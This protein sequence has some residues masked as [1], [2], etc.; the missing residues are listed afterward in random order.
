MT[1]LF[2]QG[3]LPNTAEL[4]S[5]F[6]EYLT[7]ERS[8]SHH[9]V[10]NYEIDLRHFIKFL[11]ERCGPRIDFETQ[12]TLKILRDFL[13][14]QIKK[15]ERSTV[16]RRLSL[17]KGFLKFLHQEGYVRKNIA[18]LIRLPRAHTRLPATLKP[19]EIVQ[20]IEQL[21]L[22]CLRHKRLKAVLELLYSAGLRVSELVGLNYADLDLPK[23]QVRVLGKGNK[24]RLV[25]IG[26][27]CR[28][29]LGEYVKAVPALQKRGDATPTFLN[30]SGGRISVR[31]IQRELQAYAIQVL[32]P[33]GALVTPHTFR[34]SCATHLLAN[35]AGLREIQELLG[36]RTLVTTQKYTH[37][38]IERLKVSY[39]SAHPKERKRRER[40]VSS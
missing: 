16:A 6:L 11:S 9:T 35:G 21:P 2:D 31:S 7:S 37:L 5:F 25:P 36:H 22:D 17:I 33:K 20:L 34:H 27:H 3:E 1:N 40:E 23:N 26:M 28:A 39:R 13:G 19:Q 4:V 29:A 38:D 14:T 32:G 10:I 8:A 30:R 24:E 15:Y 18:R 12:V